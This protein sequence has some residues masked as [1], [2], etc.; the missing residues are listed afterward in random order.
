MYKRQVSGSAGK[1]AVFAVRL[2]TYDTPKKNQVF[3]VGSNNSDVF[4]EIRRHILSEFKKLPTS[5]DYLH[6]DSYDAAKKYS[7]DTFIVIEKLGTN[8]LPTLFELKRKVDLLSKK[9]KFLPNRLSDKIMQFLSKLWP[10]HLPKR[11]EQFR[12]KYEHHWV[13][14]MSDDCLLYTSPSPRD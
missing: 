2:D 14:E 12:D 11:M 13:I 8:F 7:K 5:G 9:M 10:N 4:W 6:R 3:Y 1:V